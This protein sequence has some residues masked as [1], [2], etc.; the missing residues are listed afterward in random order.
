MKAWLCCMPPLLFDWDIF[1][2]GCLHHGR[3][4]GMCYKGRVL[5]LAC[6]AQ[7]FHNRLG[8]MFIL[9]KA[10]VEWVMAVVVQK[11]D[12]GRLHVWGRRVPRTPFKHKSLFWGHRNV[13]GAQW[14]NHHLTMTASYW[15][16][17]FLFFFHLAAEVTDVNVPTR[18]LVVA[19]TPTLT[20]IFT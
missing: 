7:P 12:L 19:I 6:Q 13:R 9:V 4:W 10:L 1:L 5:A 18:K 14:K 20:L 17:F 11:D 2:D 3:R 15:S 16:S 8:I